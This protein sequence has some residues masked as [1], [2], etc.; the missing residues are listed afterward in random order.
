MIMQGRIIK[1]IAGFYYV[2]CDNSFTYEC[3]AKGIFRRDRVKPMVGDIVDI[4][5]LSEDERLGNITGLSSRKSE[6]VRPAVSNVDQAL[7]VFALTHPEPNYLL[8]DKLLLQFLIQDVPTIICFNKEDL[9]R[10]EETERVRDIYKGSGAQIFFTCAT[11]HQGTDELKLSLKGKLSCVAGPSG[12]G[13]SSLIN[14]LQGQAVMATGDISRKLSRG[15]HTTRHSEII[16]IDNDT[17]IMDTPGFSSF[18]V[19]G[20]DRDEIMG[21]YNEF[22]SHTGCRFNPCSHTHEPGCMVKK[23]VDEGLIYGTRYMNYTQ[24]YNEIK[25]L[26]RY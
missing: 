19:M 22:R 2:Y 11:S 7:I 20:V 10:E 26:R 5:V 12:V 25:S 18:D 16:P 23:A 24:I 4:E 17:F 15:K 6:L 3:K 8:L 1:G 9:V 13:K 21:Y 14:C